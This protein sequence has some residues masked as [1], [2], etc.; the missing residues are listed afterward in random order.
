VSFI[1]RLFYYLGGVGLGIIILMFFLS[2]KKTSCDYGP[3][4]R[5]LKFLKS[6]PLQKSKDA[7]MD[8]TLHNI[9][10]LDIKAALDVGEI[11]FSSSEISN[12]LP[13]IYALEINLENKGS[14][15]FRFKVKKDSIEIISIE[16]FDP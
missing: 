8:I 13:N 6:K 14:F 9:D 3:N 15:E 2:G 7:E 10:S 1:K 5:T 11:N 12:D 16:P 4:A